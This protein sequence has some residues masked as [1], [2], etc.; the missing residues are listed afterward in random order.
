M[1]VQPTLEEAQ[2]QVAKL[3]EANQKLTDSLF[4]EVHKYVTLFDQYNAMQVIFVEYFSFLIN[5][6]YK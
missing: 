1:S 4:A 6:K 5:L 3:T 2:A